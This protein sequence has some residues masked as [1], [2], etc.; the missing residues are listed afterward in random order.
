M[1][2][3]DIQ[4]VWAMGS[5]IFAIMLVIRYMIKPTE[6]KEKTELETM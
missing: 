5:V 6:G 2:P 3:W 1:L 4:L